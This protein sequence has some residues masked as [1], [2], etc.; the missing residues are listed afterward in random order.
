MLAGLREHLRG[1][2]AVL[3]SDYHKGVVT[4]GVMREVRARARRLGLPVLVD[5]KVPHF[6]RY[7]GATLVTPN[8]LEAEQATK[9]DEAIEAL[10]ALDR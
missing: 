4:A 5:P 1:C 3:V 6:P 8:Q 7:R 2:E 10:V 9:V